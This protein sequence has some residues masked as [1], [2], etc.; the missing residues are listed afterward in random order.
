MKSL[1]SRTDRLN[2]PIQ[3][4]LQPELEF[5]RQPD[6]VETIPESALEKVNF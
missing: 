6:R 5:Y 2:S 3:D 1:G 4:D